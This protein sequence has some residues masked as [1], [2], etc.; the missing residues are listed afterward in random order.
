MLCGPMKIL[1]LFSDRRK[2]GPADPVL[3]MCRELRSGGHEVLLA[4]RSPQ[5]RDL[6]HRR[7]RDLEKAVDRS[8]VP[9][10]TRFALNRYM[11]PVD[12][13]RDLFALPRFL[14]AQRFDIVHTHLR[15]DQFLGLVSARWAGP[16]RPR[17]VMTMHRRDVLPATAAYRALLRRADGILVFTPAFRRA[18]IERFDLD[19]QRVQCIPPTIDAQQFDPSRPFKDIR[20]ELDIP[21]KA[22]VI[23]IVGRYQ[24]YRK[25]DV[26]MAA[27]R[28]LVDRHDDVR[29]LVVGA[30]RSRKVTVG[31]PRRRLGLTQHVV[32]AGYRGED[33]MDCLAAMDIF[34]LLMPGSDGTARAVREAMAMARP[35]VVSDFGML[36]ELV[37]HE[38][39]GLIT[40][41]DDD[42]TS[43]AQAWSRLVLDADLRQRLGGAG[44]LMAVERFNPSAAG[45]ALVEFYRRI[46]ELPPR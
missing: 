34:T 26:F 24:P 16:R 33:Y 32:I 35:C 2:T 25:M 21:A 6:H 22:V 44:R 39:A 15:H 37:G 4:Y 5:R 29:F 18:Y 28:K 12:T 10:T 13:V 36:P 31:E 14:R 7:A 20:G 41:I 38:Q 45:E 40:R 11:N 3:R 43:L 17:V 19:E 42:G 27:A 8:G 1:H 30:S 46:V 9:A 23:G